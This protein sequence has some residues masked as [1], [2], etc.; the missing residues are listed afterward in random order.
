MDELYDLRDD[1]V[2]MKN[3]ALLPAYRQKRDELKKQ[4]LAWHDP[5]K[6]VA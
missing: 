6:E 2:E 5:G 1:P 4:L 3:L